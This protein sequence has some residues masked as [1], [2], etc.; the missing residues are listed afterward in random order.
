MNNTTNQID[1]KKLIL[2][3]LG[4]GLIA[5]AILGL[6]G[7]SQLVSSIATGAAVALL[8][9]LAPKISWLRKSE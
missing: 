8:L 3:M 9:T 7:A 1:W 2:L 6:L 5:G 4:L